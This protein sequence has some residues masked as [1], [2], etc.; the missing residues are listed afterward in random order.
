MKPTKL[1]LAAILLTAGTTFAQQLTNGSFEDFV[2]DQQA[3]DGWT[4]WG[5]GIH[6]ETTWWPTLSGKALLGYRHWQVKGDFTSGVWQD[7]PG[8]KAGQKVKFSVSMMVDKHEDGANTAEEV[9]LLLECTKNGQ[10]ETIA[11]KKVPLADFPADGQ[12]H[13]IS[14]EG[15]T[16]V[17]SLRVLI[18]AQPAREGSRTS[19][20][21]FDDASLE[22]LN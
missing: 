8:V 4:T 20:V 6:R 9:E 11:S 14:V 1:I 5:E 2:D 22:V 13:E 19:A 21:K 18:S 3:P 7:V 16:P 12:W 17:N 10:Q 15:T